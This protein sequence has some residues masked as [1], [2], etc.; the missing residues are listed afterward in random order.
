MWALINSAGCQ[1][2]VAMQVCLDDVVVALPTCV[3]K[4]FKASIQCPIFRWQS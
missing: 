1:V 2:F 3:V 4:D